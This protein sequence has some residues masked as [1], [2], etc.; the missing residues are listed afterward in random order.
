MYEIRFLFYCS[1]I[2][3]RNTILLIPYFIIKNI[4]FNNRIHLYDTDNI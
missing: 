1:Y 2:S 3:L 4:F